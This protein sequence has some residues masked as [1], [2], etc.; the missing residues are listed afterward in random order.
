MKFKGYKWAVLA[1]LWLLIFAYGANWFAVAPLLK[2][3]ESLYGIGGAESHLLLSIIGLF[4]VF[5]AWPAGGVVDK[6]G[7]RMSA[8]IGSVFMVVGFTGRIWLNGSY[9][10]LL[11]TTAVAGIGLAWLLVALAPQLIQWFE[12]KASLMIGL[13]SSGLFMGFATASL[14]SPYIKEGYGIKAVYEFFALLSIIAFAA[15]LAFGKDKGGS[16]EKSVKISEGMK[17]LFSSRNAILYPMIGFFIVGATLS[18]SA[19]LPK[20]LGDFG[21]DE[22]EGGNVISIMLFG[23]AL[24]AFLFPHVAGKYG[25]KKSSLAVASI[26]VIFWLVFHFDVSFLV[27]LLAAFLFGI[28]LESSWPV[29]LHCQETEKGVNAKNVGIA[30]SLYISISNVGG[31]TLPVII[32]KLADSSHQNAFVVLLSYLV[33]FV[34]LWAAVKK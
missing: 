26:S 32:G 28:F 3:F 14:L 9:S 13:A 30:A 11:F 20:L 33:I 10:E 8:I 2:D 18:A 27:Y 23:A 17:S 31:A 16:K 4:V 34:L 7:P 22:V 5:L 29:A 12:E 21:M 19:L 24:G 15:Y 1:S 6:K 25:V